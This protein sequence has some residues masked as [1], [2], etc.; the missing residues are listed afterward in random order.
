[1]SDALHILHCGPGVTVQDPGRPDLGAIGLS[2][3]GAADRLAL[4]EAAALLGLAR[5][6][7]ALEMMGL[8][9][10]FEVDKPTRIALTG[11]P[12]QARIDGRAIAWNAT[13]LLA[14]GQT[15]SIGGAL[16]GVFGY[17]SF[18][19][20]IAT[21]E[22]LGSRAT[23][24]AAGLGAVLEPG[25]TLPLADDPAPA[26]APG[27]LPPG[28][29][30][31][32]G[33]LRY[34]YGPQS[35]LFSRETVGRFEATGFTRSPTGNRQGVKLEADA[36][37]FSS[38]APSDLASEFIFEGDIQMTGGGEPYVLLAECQTMGGY[39]RI[40]TVIPADLPRIAQARP[41]DR[42]TFTRVALADLAALTP[43]PAGQLA[44]IKARVRPLLR[45]PHDIPDLLSYDLISGVTAGDDLEDPG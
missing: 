5:P 41:G 18:A 22:V 35:G 25:A 34:T 20:G 39:P 16:E 30:Y 3:G 36:A 21:E 14:P 45:T 4:L 40:G 19:G 9:G 27:C 2:R 38:E 17:L 43:D 6:D 37:A 24:L 15:L 13:H 8:G 33:V 31:R 26:T 44:E 32:G 12:M 7:A 23:H 28:D 29:R 1:M 11:A 10:S 42:L